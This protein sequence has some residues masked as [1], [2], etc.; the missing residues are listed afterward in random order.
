MIKI[1]VNIISGFL[2]AGKTTA[3]LKLLSQKANDEPWAVVINEF[4]KISIDTKTLQSASDSENVY[5]IAGGCICCTAKA[6]LNDTLQSV[7]QSG[8][9]SRI[10]IEPTGLGGVDMVSEIVESQPALFLNPVICL[11]DI[12]RVTNP[13]LNRIPVF[14]A[15]ISKSDWVVF[16]KT[17][18]IS[19][20]PKL[21][22]LKQQFLT[23][24]PTASITDEITLSMLDGKLENKITAIP[25][26]ALSYLNS[27]SSTTGFFEKNYTFEASTVFDSQKLSF[28]F[29]K[30]ASVIRAKGFVNTETGWKLINYSLS[31]CNFEPVDLQPQTQIVIIAD[32]SES[33]LETTL[34]KEIS[35]AIIST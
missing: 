10:I 17:D 22:E 33:G 7:I 32:K 29:Q 16:S 12:Q 25:Q 2:G 26:L 30:H 5:E 13:K 23:L 11:V 18:L 15:Q 27:D 6:Y 9:Y 34:E 20:H 1:P 14:R 24:F 8:K 3:I 4:G 21:F 35:E 19:D 28:V 31:E